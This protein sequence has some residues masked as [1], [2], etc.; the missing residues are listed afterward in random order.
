MAQF[1]P[2]SNRQIRPGE[3]P[4]LYRIYRDVGDDSPWYDK[5]IWQAITTLEE[6]ADGDVRAECVQAEAARRLGD[7][8]K[9]LGERP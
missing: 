5:A 3:T 2:Q 1:P 4:E 6:I 9:T 7:I 8:E